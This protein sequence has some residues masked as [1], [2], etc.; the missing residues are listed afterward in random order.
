[1]IDIKELCYYYYTITGKNEIKGRKMISFNLV[2]KAYGKNKVLDDVSVEIKEDRIIFIMGENGAGKTTLIK[3]M[4]DIE[5]YNG[6]I[7]F[8]NRKFRDV[9]KDFYVLFDDCPFYNNF[10]GIENLVI[11]SEGKLS[12]GEIL[13]SAQKFLERK[14]LCSKVKNYSNG[15]RKKLGIILVDILKPKYIIL[16]EV[17]NGLDYES[18]KDLKAIIKNWSENSTIIMTG[19]QF[20]FYNDLIDDLYLLKEG[21][22]IKEESFVQG[23][24]KLEEV[25]DEKLYKSR[26]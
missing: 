4:V 2:G 1:M 26:I 14:V 6:K 21:K 23:E 25:Y 12:K 8:N 7:L 19:H 20:D 5:G 9:R 22:I 3:C 11:F 10:S 15:Q 16:D 17:S 24:R 13:K 18:L